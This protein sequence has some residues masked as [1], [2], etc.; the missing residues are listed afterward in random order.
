MSK[1]IQTN[2]GFLLRIPRSI[3]LLLPSTRATLS[4]SQWKVRTNFCFLRTILYPS[5]SNLGFLLHIPRL[6]P[7]LLPSPS[8]SQWKV[9][10]F[11]LNDTESLT[12]LEGMY[13]PL[14]CHQ[15]THKNLEG[16]YFLF[17]RHWSINPPYCIL[18]VS[19]S[20]TDYWSLVL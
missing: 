7:L 5:T 13:F 6:V 20:L 1:S 14:P 12:N 9:R 16:S 2:L 3:P 19:M 15:V 8:H 17:Q 18:L 11:N 4:H 10:T